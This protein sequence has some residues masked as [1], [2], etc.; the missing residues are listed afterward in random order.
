MR[1]TEADRKAFNDVRIANDRKKSVAE[2]LA[3]NPEIG[4]L[5]NGTYYKFVDGEMVT[6]AEFAQQA[7]P[8][9]LKSD[10]EMSRDAA[11]RQARFRKATS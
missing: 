1:H 2:W 5:N 11:S 10:E 3:N 9:V 4:V 8:P 6:V 7:K